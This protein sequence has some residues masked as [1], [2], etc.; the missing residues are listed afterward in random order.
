MRDY[1]N[2]HEDRVKEYSKLKERLA[3]EYS[4]NR[5]SYTNGKTT[6]IEDILRCAEKWRMQQL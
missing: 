2:E 5:S 6:L 1:L 4:D 3:K